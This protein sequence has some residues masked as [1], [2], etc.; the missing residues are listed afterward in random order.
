MHDS[1]RDLML[2]LF[3]IVFFMFTIL[4]SKAIVSLI[5]VVGDTEVG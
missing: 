3:L 2:Y 5:H 4:E 1:W